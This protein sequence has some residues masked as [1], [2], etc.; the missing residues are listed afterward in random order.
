MCNLVDHYDEP[1]ARIPQHESFNAISTVNQISSC[2]ALTSL[3]YLI[4][5]SYFEF[6]RKVPAVV[7]AVCFPTWYFTKAYAENEAMKEGVLKLHFPKTPEKKEN[8]AP[9]E[10]E[11]KSTNLASKKDD[12][13]DAS[14]LEFFLN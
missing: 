14:C 10:E 2:A 3:V 6:D 8:N 5:S 9:R 7:F 11:L 4:A 1:A 13:S 12:D